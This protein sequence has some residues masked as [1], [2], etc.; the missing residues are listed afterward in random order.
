V[1]RRALTRR[2]RRDLPAVCALA[3]AAALSACSGDDG[4]STPSTTLPEGLSAD[5][6]VVRLHGKSETGAE[7]EVRDGVAE[8]APT[9]N[10]EA[11]DGHEWVYDP[12][13]RYDE[14]VAVVADVVE[15]AGCTR[16]VLD[17]FSNG[18]AFAATVACRGETFG[19]TLVGVVV[20]D[21]PP[22]EGVVD[23]APAPGVEV[24]LYWTGALD[25]QA[26]PGADCDDIGWTCAGGRLLG[27]DAYAEALGVEVQESPYDE[28]R[29]YRDAPEI[30]AWLA[31]G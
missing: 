4:S 17:G 6:C 7:A 14:A 31:A 24:A 23:C 18:A 10:G 2:L 21:P 15:Q 5:R 16:V 12:E 28:H 26:Q 11:G 27:L 25:E 9:G 22:D 13:E 29:W 30:E 8:L 20:D 1:A 19:D 3:V